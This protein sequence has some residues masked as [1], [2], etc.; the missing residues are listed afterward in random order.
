M[1]KF[2]NDGRTQMTGQTRYRRFQAVSSKRLTLSRLC[3]GYDGKYNIVSVGQRGSYITTAEGRT[4]IVR[5]EAIFLAIPISESRSAD[6]SSV[7]WGP[8]NSVCIK[9]KKVVIWVKKQ[10]EAKFFICKDL[11]KK[12]SVNY[13]LSVLFSTAC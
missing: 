1:A 2:C 11:K 13:F 5:G 9:P 3:E 8:L 4:M 12:G 7:S 6:R 10:G